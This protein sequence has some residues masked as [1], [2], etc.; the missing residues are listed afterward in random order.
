MIHVMWPNA[1]PK[2]MVDGLSVLAEYFKTR[3][4]KLPFYR[5]GPSGADLVVT[6]TNAPDLSDLDMG[7]EDKS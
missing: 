2:K 1:D 5:T 7:K 6:D 3:R 4:P